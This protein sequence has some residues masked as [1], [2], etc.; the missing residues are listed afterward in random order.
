M[1]FLIMYNIN[2]KSP[3]QLEKSFVTVMDEMAIWNFKRADW[4]RKEASKPQAPG[5]IQ[6]VWTF[7]KGVSRIFNL[8]L[9]P[10]KY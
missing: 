5:G 1:Y 6:I 4:H 2:L 10:H 7:K 9:Y 8:F 3:L